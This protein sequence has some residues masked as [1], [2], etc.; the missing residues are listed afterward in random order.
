M[1]YE[2]YNRIHSKPMLI[3]VPGMEPATVTIQ[4]PVRDSGPSAL[5]L[6]LVER[7]RPE[8]PRLWKEML[9]KLQADWGESDPILYD[10]VEAFWKV[11]ILIP[12]WEDTRDD[13]ELEP[14]IEPSIDNFSWQLFTGTAIP[15]C[16][17]CHAEFEGLKFDYA[18]LHW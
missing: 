15:G 1:P 6:E 4:Y 9:E 13:P 7:I 8:F 10:P 11:Q 14:P 3:P 16:S 17:G 18:T 2:E 5:Q 12:P